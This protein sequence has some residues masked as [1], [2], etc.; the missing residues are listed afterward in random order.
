MTVV[1]AD[2]FINEAAGGILPAVDRCQAGIRV[3]PNIGTLQANLRDHGHTMPP[4]SLSAATS[5]AASQPWTDFGNRLL[6]AINSWKQSLIQKF[7]RID[8][9]SRVSCTS[10]NLSNPNESQG[11]SSLTDSPA[12]SWPNETKADVHKRDEAPQ[13]SNTSVSVNLT[14]TT[15]APTPLPMDPFLPIMSDSEFIIAAPSTSGL[16]ASEVPLVVDLPPSSP[17]SGLPSLAVASPNALS[18]ITSSPALPLSD[19]CSQCSIIFKYVSVYY[20]PA[21]SSNT[22]CLTNGAEIPSPSLPPGLVPEVNTRN[23][24]PGSAYVVVPELSA[25]NAC[26]KIAEFTSRTFT[27]GPGELSTIQG[28]ANLTKEFNFADLPCPPPDV[29]ADVKWF[30]NPEFNPTRTYMPVVAPFSQLYD[31]HPDFHSC[32]VALNQGFDPP[33]ALPSVKGPTLPGDKGRIGHFH[34]RRHPVGAHKVPRF[35]MQTNPPLRAERI[36]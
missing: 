11:L 35:P 31:M 33:I 9:T 16:A 29:A 4:A 23:R 24:E 15:A 2:E 1:D 27:F 19:D 3:E 7:E 8:Q 13:G 20:P 22:E 10:S 21:A 28:P 34:P 5:T 36:G 26:T 12:A 30:Y 6:Q 14:P 25:G 32:T 17:L 18:Q